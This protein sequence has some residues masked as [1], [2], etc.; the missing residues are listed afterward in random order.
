MENEVQ[1]YYGNKIRVRI[2]GLCIIDNKLLL[3]NHNSITNTNF[4]APPGGGLNFGESAKDCLKREFMEET[5]LV[6]EPG[7]F[8]FA[9]EF[10]KHPLHAVELFFKVE[11]LTSHLKIGTDPEPGS[12]AIIKDVKFRSWKEIQAIPP[13]E[14][15]GIFQYA[16]HPS[17][18]EQLSGYFKL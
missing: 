14:V 8:L 9:C 5:G 2:C 15:H 4:W 1:A 11:P 17:K 3:I 13:E 16:G 10:I 12:P 18:I 7:N 6:V